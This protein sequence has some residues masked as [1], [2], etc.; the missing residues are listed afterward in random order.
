MPGDASLAP[1]EIT[2][3]EG[4][5][6]NDL[7]AKVING[8]GGI[9]DEDYG[10]LLTGEEETEDDAEET[11]QQDEEQ[12]DEEV[13]QTVESLQTEADDAQAFLTKHGVDSDAL[14]DEYAE[15][16]KLSKASLEALAKAGI[17]EKLVSGY[18]KGQQARMDVYADRVYAIAGG[19]KEYTK[20]MQWAEKHLTE[21]E[22][23]HYDK[24][25][26]SHDID[27][28]R[29]AVEGIMARREKQIG[30]APKLITGKAP[31][32]GAAVK[33][34]RSLEEMA[35]AQDDPRYETDEA[36]TRMVERRMLNSNF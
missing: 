18:I 5:E 7:A 10:D 11:Q 36:Y 25:V 34:F 20:L 21:K 35:K 12:R 14:V 30:V 19:E 13:R 27:E 1:M 29:F 16:G 32:L 9:D 22:I 17:G 2:I 26:N 3:P 4:V 24:A 31:K 28:A 6:Q 33:G 8:D 23:T 15:D